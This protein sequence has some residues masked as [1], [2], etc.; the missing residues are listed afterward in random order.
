MTDCPGCPSMMPA[1]GVVKLKRGNSWHYQDSQALVNG[2]VQSQK[3]FTAEKEKNKI[4]FIHLAKSAQFRE[5]WQLILCVNVAK[6]QY[7]N[8][9]PN[10]VLH[11]SEEVFFT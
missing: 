1:I 11:V 8:I 3:S 7:P 4:Q 10:T 9:W 5:L 2:P 6:P